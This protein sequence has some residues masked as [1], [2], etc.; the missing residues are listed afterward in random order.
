MSKLKS[1]FNYLSKRPDR[2]YTLGELFQHYAQGKEWLRIEDNR[3]GFTR[4]GRSIERAVTVSAILALPIALFSN[5][6][7]SI[8]V[9]T[10]MLPFSKFAGI[11]LGKTYDHLLKDSSA[12][13][14][15]PEYCS[16]F[17][18]IA[19]DYKDS[20]DVIVQKNNTHGP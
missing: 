16:P 14:L 9:V 6:L 15:D 1:T 17:Q 3:L 8:L 2:N 12:G 5:D 18:R 10:A 7:K 19:K 20:K 11:F 13:Y 4:L